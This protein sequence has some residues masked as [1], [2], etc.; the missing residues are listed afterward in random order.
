VTG[1][2]AHHRTLH[3]AMPPGHASM[4]NGLDFFAAYITNPAAGVAQALLFLP[5]TA[6]FV[7][8]ANA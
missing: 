7:T 4:S 8:G 6:L 3:V 2:C 5:Q 1:F